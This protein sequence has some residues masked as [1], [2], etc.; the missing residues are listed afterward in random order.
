MSLMNGQ[1]VS[2]RRIA[3]NRRNA[4]ESTGPRTAEGKRRSSGN[5]AR[6]RLCP[7][8]FREAKRSPNENPQE[9]EQLYQDLID[10]CRPANALEAMLVEDL[11]KL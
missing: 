3:A 11:A 10:S 7:K 5:V 8:S 6:R 9:F 4:L 2:P 1:Q